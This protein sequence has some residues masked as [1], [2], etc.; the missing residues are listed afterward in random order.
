MDIR[1]IVFGDTLFACAG[2][3]TEPSPR[4]LARALA[5]APAVHRVAAT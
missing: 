5:L 1:S 4:A 2:A 3:Q